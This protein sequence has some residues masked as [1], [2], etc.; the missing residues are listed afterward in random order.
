MVLQ[1][2]DKG[3]KGKV[4]RVLPENG[5]VV[6]EGINLLIKHVRAKREREK[7]Q[8][9]QF[10]AAMPVS[11]VIL[12]CSRCGRVTRVGYQILESGKKV[13]VCKKCHD[14]I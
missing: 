11:K 4:I 8:R 14:V 3:K 2:K 12:V 7:G 1:G 13:R 9:V 5:R 10:P 6:V